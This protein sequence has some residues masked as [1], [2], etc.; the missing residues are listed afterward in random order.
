MI[1][2]AVRGFA[3]KLR[4]TTPRERA[5]LAALVAIAAL[6]AAVY[7][8]EWAST[9]AAAAASATQTASES[10]AM[11]SAFQSETYRQRLSTQAGNAWRWSQA[12]DAF[13]GETVLAELDSMSQQAGFNEPRVALVEQPAAEGQ[14]GAIEA[15]ISADF[16]W[17]SFLAFLDALEESELSFTIRSIDVA[18]EA[19]AQ[20]IALI[21]TVPTIAESETR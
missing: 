18:E 20:R 17:T 4:Q 6:T 19:G 7:G 8:M 5:G 16:D 9:N 13:A 2:A 10:E 1:A 14:V 21:I 11:L 12:S 15:S 3:A